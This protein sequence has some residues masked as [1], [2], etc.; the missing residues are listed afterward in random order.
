MSDNPSEVAGRFGISA[1]RAVNYESDSAGTKLNYQVFSSM[2]S[3]VRRSRSREEID[4]VMELCCESI[5]ENYEK[6]HNKKRASE[7]H[8]KN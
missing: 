2:V 7:N 5:R 6:R 3:G 8:N 4:E 1:N